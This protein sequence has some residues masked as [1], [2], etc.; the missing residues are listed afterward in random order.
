MDTTQTTER[1]KMKT[2]VD[3]VDSMMAFETS[4]PEFDFG[5]INNDFDF[6]QL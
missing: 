2:E 6:G 1:P 5:D 4:F 3:F